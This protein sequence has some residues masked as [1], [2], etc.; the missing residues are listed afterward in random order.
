MIGRE[1]IFVLLHN[2]ENQFVCSLLQLYFH[3]ADITLHLFDFGDYV[4]ARR[5]L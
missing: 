4:L 1:C 3:L 5:V 2:C